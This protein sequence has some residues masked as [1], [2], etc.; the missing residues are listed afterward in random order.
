MV[1]FL[2][3]SCGSGT[4]LT[5]FFRPSG[6]LYLIPRLSF[7]TS[8]AAPA[9]RRCDHGREGISVCCSVGVRMTLFWGGCGEKILSIT[10]D[11]SASESLSTFDNGRIFLCRQRW[12]GKGAVAA[13]MAMAF[14]GAGLLAGETGRAVETP[15]AIIGRTCC[16]LSGVGDMLGWL[17]YSDQT[18]SAEDGYP[19]TI[20]GCLAQSD[21]SGVPPLAMLSFIFETDQMPAIFWTAATSWKAWTALAA[22]YR[23]VVLRLFAYAFL[24][25]WYRLIASLLFLG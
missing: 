19:M 3:V 12:A 11:D 22:V 20:I 13:G 25:L 15:L 10:N 21:G 2:N 23:A 6:R 4:V 8:P 16:L 24:C 14:V 9:P 18:D 1:R 17:E 7:G 5:L